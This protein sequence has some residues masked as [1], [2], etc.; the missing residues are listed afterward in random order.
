MHKILIIDD[1]KDICFLIAEIL[2]DENY[3]TNYAINS[4]KALMKFNDFNP[5][6]IILDVWLSNSK[7][8]G[9]ELLTKFKKIN[10]NC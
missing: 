2:K 8:E 7:L 3:I 1:E 4:D 5:D 6:L 9:I 10:N